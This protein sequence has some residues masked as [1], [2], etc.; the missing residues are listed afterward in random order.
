[1]EGGAGARRLRQVA[2]HVAGGAACAAP[3]RGPLWAPRHLSRGAA[4][5]HGACG[6][7]PLCAGARYSRGSPCNYC[8]GAPLLRAHTLYGIMSDNDACGVSCEPQLYVNIATLRGWIDSVI[9]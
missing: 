1:M 8:A 5:Q 2:V 6:A 4:A 3:E 9:E 7:A